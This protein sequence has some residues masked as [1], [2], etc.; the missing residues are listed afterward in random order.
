MLFAARNG[1]CLPDCCPATSSVP[2]GIH[3]LAD[4]ESSLGTSGK[5]N[6]VLPLENDQRRPSQTTI[7]PLSHVG[8]PT[9]IVVLVS[10]VM[11]GDLTLTALDCI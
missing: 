5:A 2:D 8:F 10:P 11:Q 9:C 6:G 7:D 4:V 3:A 1:M